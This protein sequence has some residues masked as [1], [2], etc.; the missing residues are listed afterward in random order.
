HD[1]VG[2]TQLVGYVVADS[3]EDAERLRESLRE[4]LKRH[5][6]DYMVPAHLMLLERMPLTVNG[7]LDR[8][9][10]PQPDA[11][12]SQQAYRAPGSELEQRIAAIWSEILG[13]ERVGL[14]DNF[15]ELG[16]HSLLRL[17]LKERIGDTCQATLSISQL[18]THAS[19][20]EQA[21]CIEGQARE[22]LL[23]PLNGRREG[24]PLFMF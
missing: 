8:Q 2:G 17:M 24:S 22:S 12:L 1:G 3:A 14:D 11:S 18:M 7:K 10:L 5:L 9:A 20:A 16:G 6:P 15:F 4:S 13:V 23:V 21:A 19:V